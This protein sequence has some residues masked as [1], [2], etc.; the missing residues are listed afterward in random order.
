FDV[1]P[2]STAFF[3]SRPAPIITLG[4]E[5]LVQEVMAAITTEP[6][7]SSKSSPST[8][9]RRCPGATV[10]TGADSSCSAAASC[11]GGSLAGKLSAT[12]L[13]Y[14]PLSYSTPNVPSASMNAGFASASGTRSCGR[15][16][17]ASE[18]ST[19]ERSS[20]TT[21]VYVGSSL[22]SCQSRFSL[23]YASTSASRRSS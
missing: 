20:S 21:C 6:W 7:S 3:A 13:S 14:E 12:S 11:V 17:P 2:A 15:R 9:T 18:G 19:A 8:L 23:Q 5:V 1:R 16:G 10:A 4:F 22:G